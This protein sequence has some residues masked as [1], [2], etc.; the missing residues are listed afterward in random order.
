MTTGAVSQA[1]AMALRRPALISCCGVNGRG[2]PPKPT[3]DCLKFKNPAAPVVKREARRT[4]QRAM[5]V[6]TAPGTNRIRIFGPKTDG[7]YIVEF[8]TAAGDSLAITIRGSEA[9][10]IRYFQE[11]AI[12]PARHCIVSLWRTE[13]IKKAGFSAAA[14]MGRAA[15]KART[16]VHEK[17]LFPFDCCGNNTLKRN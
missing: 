10:A 11:R 7:T 2:D 9:A 12:R 4:G 8:R 15:A 16:Q 17:R 1:S 6:R 5:A 3:S 13:R 14:S